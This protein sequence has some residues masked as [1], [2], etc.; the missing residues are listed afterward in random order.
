M[1]AAG[2]VL[3]YVSAWNKCVTFDE[4][5]H[6]FAGY[7]YL[8]TGDY[9]LTPEHPPLI[10]ILCAAPLLLMDLNLPDL[11]SPAALTAGGWD[12]GDPFLLGRAWLFTAGNDPDRIMR[13]ARIP[14]LLIAA[15]GGWMLFRTARRAAGDAAAFVVL[16]LWCFSPTVLAHARLVTTDMAAAVFFFAATMAFW[17]LTRRVTVLALVST[18]ASFAA[19]FTTKFSAVLMLPVVVLLIVVRLRCDGVLTIQWSRTRRR[20]VGSLPGRAAVLTCCLVM[21]GSGTIGSIW[22]CFS[23]RFC[24]SLDGRE[25]YLRWTRHA[26]NGPPQD[27][28]DAMTT[29]PEGA[30]TMIGRLILRAKHHRLLPEAYLYGL[31]YTLKSVEGRMAY[32]NGEVRSTGWWYY[33]PYA[34]AVKTTLPALLL[35]TGGGL[36]WLRALTARGDSDRLRRR[37]IVEILYPCLVLGVVYLAASM[38]SALNIGQRHVLPLY[39]VLFVLACGWFGP[40]V[41]LPRTARGSAALLVVLHII[42]AAGVHPHYLAYFNHL[43]GG[44]RHAW[45]HLCGSN[46]DWGQDL[47]HLRGYL[48]RRRPQ[49]VD[50]VPLKLSYFGTA[51]PN[52]YLG[53]VE[54]LPSFLPFKPDVV[55][56]LA[57]ERSPAP[58]APL[59]PGLYLI[60]ATHLS[61]FYARFGPDW[62]PQNKARLVE[63]DDFLRWIAA[64]R[65]AGDG[66]DDVI[67]AR[68]HFLARQ[69]PPEARTSF[70]G[71]P[72]RYQHVWPELIREI[73]RLH[74]DLRF[75]ALIVFLRE[76]EP[77]ERIGDTIYVYQVTEQDIKRCLGGFA[78]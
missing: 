13:V 57:P 6:L 2:F 9:R 25:H 72:T 24:G 36:L 8:R 56:A 65:D 20:P 12:R 64:A 19:L 53:T 4:P 69:F 71:D 29:S 3:G 51:D 16:A 5:S 31:A 60:S 54:M 1:I 55:S 42:L 34:V 18:I 63:A 35:A 43:V 78:G 28:W 73:E 61:G 67:F 23:F 75:L 48:D 14:I 58:A 22:A 50:T 45:R 39:P 32:L 7:S 49:D 77:L 11:S 40:G 76:Q 74:Y 47:I 26:S 10:E 15:L 41:M 21:I 62:S 33:F 68:R 46:L 59:T 70:M 44:P 17:R 66:I 27:E 52:Y 37:R 38:T 30:R